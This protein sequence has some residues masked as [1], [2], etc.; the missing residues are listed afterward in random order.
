MSSQPNNPKSAI[1]LPQLRPGITFKFHDYD[2]EGKPQWLLHDSG[3]NKFFLLGWLEYEILSRWTLKDQA[4]ILES[5]QQDTTLNISME[6]IEHF[7]KFLTTNFLIEQ[8]GYKIS[9]QA[10]DQ[11]LFKNDNIFKWLV[12]NYLF[13]KVPVCHPDKFLTKTK[14]LGDILFSRYLS[15]IMIILALIATW[16]ISMRWETFIHTFSKIFSL[17][18]IFFY[19]IAFMVCK[20]VHEL[21]HAYMCK[22]FGVPVPTLGVAFL[23]FWPVLY[24]DTTLSWSLDHKKRMKI[25]LAGIWAE[26]YITIFAALLWCN[27]DQLTLK[28]I[29]YMVIAVNWIGSLLINVS[30]FMRFDGYYVLADY[31]RMPNLQPR[32]FA[33]TRWQIRR[34]LFNWPE[35]A[36]EKFNAKRHWFLIIYSIITWLYRLVIYFG[37]AILVY[38]FSVKIIGIILFIIEIFYFILAPFFNEVKFLLQNKDKFKFNLNT[39]TTLITTVLIIL[40]FLLPFN[41]NLTLPATISY[42]HNFIQTTDAGILLTNLPPAGTKVVKNQVLAKIFSPDL[43]MAMHIVQLN[44]QKTLRE[45]RRASVNSNYTA[46]A[47]VLRSKINKDSSQYNRLAERNNRL[48]IRAPFDGIIVD[49]PTDILPGTVVKKNDWLGDIIL[50]NNFQIEAFVTQVDTSRLKLGL[51]GTF[52]PKNFEDPA[53]PVT[54]KS[55]EVLNS[56]ELNCNFSSQLKVDNKQNQVVETACYNSSDFG[57]D[58]ATQ[59]NDKGNYV[60][61][62]SVYRVLLEPNNQPKAITLVEKG[63][64]ILNTTPRSLGYRLFYQLKKIWIEQS[65]F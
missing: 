34:W 43:K 30:P 29:C 64:V 7:L 22:R 16:Q 32:A 49:S 24:T 23:V 21:G 60:P 54:V 53:I 31:L 44:Y 10:K 58:I 20:L 48:T 41:Q 55:I 51:K 25:A 59:L 62:N 1:K 11:E 65:G 13:F 38:N 42:Q 52:Y 18:G 45:L 6:D 35:P 27:S 47:I 56:S 3:R 26:T 9:Q 8:S 61:V 19:F 33:L 46:E 5:I 14:I 2:T 12:S 50:S 28:S 63:T 39:I 37:I 15:Y 4:K 40:F 57:G 36:P 17:Q